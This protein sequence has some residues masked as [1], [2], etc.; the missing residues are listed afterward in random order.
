M[1]YQ[2]KSVGLT[3]TQCFTKTFT[4]MICFYTRRD[5]VALQLYDVELKGILW[6]FTETI[7]IT[8]LR[9]ASYISKMNINK[10]RENTRSSMR[11]RIFYEKKYAS[12]YNNVSKY[13][14]YR[15]KITV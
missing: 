8:Q 4:D 1:K 7:M 6:V 15:L 14:D 5:G 13:E 9:V 10:Y 11:F 2:I 12:I 3:K